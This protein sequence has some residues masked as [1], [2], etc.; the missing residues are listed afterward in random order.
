MVCERVVLLR[1]E[2]LE[3]R[4]RRTSVVGIR[5][6]VHLV[7]NDYRIRNAALLDSV[8]DAARHRAYVCPSVSADIRFI[9]HAAKADSYVFASERPC[10][11]LS[12]A[13]LAGARSSHEQQ[14]RARLLL[15]QIHHGDLLDYAV[16]HL[17]ETVVILVEHLARLVQI[18]MLCLFLLPGKPCDEV[19]V[20]IEHSRLGALSSVLFQAVQDLV[21]LLARGL[22][23]AR[24]R[25]LL[26]KHA[27]VGYVLRMHLVELLLEVL[28]LALYRLLAVHL[29][30]LFLLGSH[31]LVGDA[32][33]LHEAVKSLLDELSAPLSAVFSEDSVTFVVRYVHPR[34]HDA[35]RSFE[36][37]DLPQPVLSRVRPVEAG[38]K[39]S[40]LLEHAVELF[41]LDAFAHVLNVV[42]SGH[43]ESYRLIVADLDVLD[44]DPVARADHDISLVI[45]FDDLPGDTYRV[46][47]L[48]SEVPVA[49]VVLRNDKNHPLT[50]SE[51][52]VARVPSHLIGVEVY[53]GVRRK[54]H[55]VYRYYYHCF[56][57]FCRQNA[58]FCRLLDIRMAHH[59]DLR[60]A[61]S[62]IM[63]PLEF[64]LAEFCL[65][66]I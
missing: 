45:Y 66:R 4:A 16:L 35:G 58:L 24:L 39:P 43:G 3:K 20:V 7:Q 8:H 29:L 40:H 34:R 56:S 64:Q 17:V 13:G 51:S 54:Y 59:R 14:D 31:G 42:S 25:Y 18:D 48:R 41:L 6:L 44:V 37:V 5:K 55:V 38:R 52:P 57:F 2:H 10:D 11:A 27:D 21:C 23:H 26:L 33:D 49:L 36:R 65:L 53:V 28:H 46:K 12:D 32:A 9:V 22:V 1:V 15:L 30:V 61:S 62:V 60:C 50:D 47:A 63:L 19:E